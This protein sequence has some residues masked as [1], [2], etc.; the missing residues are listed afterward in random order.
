MVDSLLH[1]LYF[2]R[3]FVYVIWLNW[4]HMIYISFRVPMMHSIISL[5]KDTCT[6]LEHSLILTFTNKYR[7]LQTSVD[8][9]SGN[10]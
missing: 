3:P 6:F 5:N 7:N 8:N 10:A 2:F 4:V 9:L 1:F